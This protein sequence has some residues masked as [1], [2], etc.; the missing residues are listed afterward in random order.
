MSR[1]GNLKKL[2]AFHQLMSAHGQRD[3]KIDRPD[4]EDHTLHENTD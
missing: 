1:W 4:Q 3:A 2:A